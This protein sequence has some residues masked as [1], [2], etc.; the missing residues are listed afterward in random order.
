M[1]KVDMKTIEIQNCTDL[2]D[3]SFKVIVNGEKHVVRFLFKT[4]VT[5]G[6]PFQIKVKYFWKVS[7]VYTFEPKDNMKLQVFANQRKI[8]RTTNLFAVG[9]V[10][11]FCQNF[12]WRTFHG[13]WSMHYLVDYSDIL[14]QYKREKFCYQGN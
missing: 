4:Q 3:N 13:N 6:K 1:I 10:L 7:R 2:K 8:I 5:D 12:L 11:S 14:L 9:W